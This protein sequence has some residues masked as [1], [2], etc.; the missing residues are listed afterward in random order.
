M[1][2]DFKKIF[3]DTAPLIYFVEK[4]TEFEQIVSNLLKSNYLKSKY[5]INTIVYTELCIKPRRLNKIE[6]IKNFD[7]FFYLLDFEILVFDFECAEIA[8]KIMAKYSFLKTIDALHIATAI[9][10]NCNIFITNDKKLKQVN[11]LE[12]IVL[13]DL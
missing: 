7:D 2:T 8:S 5:F 4:N 10:N 9:K 1:K 11:E 13:S 6:I 12:I 3:W